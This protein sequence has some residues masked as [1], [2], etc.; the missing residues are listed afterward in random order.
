M[1]PPSSDDRT[2][3][4]SVVIAT[5]NTRAL[6]AAALTSLVRSAPGEILEI[7]VV[8]NGSIDGSAEMIREQF[9]DVHLIRLEKNTGYAPANNRGIRASHGTYVL[10]LG[11]DTAVKADTLP[12]MRRFLDDHP[13]VSAVACRLMNPDGTPQMSCRRFPRLRDAVATYLSLYSL[14]ARYVMKDFDFYRTQEV[15]QPAA[16]SLMV[17]REVLEQL[18]GFD[19]AYTI[20]Y[21]DVD[22]CRRMQSNGGRIFYLAETEVMHHGS[23]TTRN[24]PPEIRLEM[25][26]NILLYFTRHHG[27]VARWV[28]TPILAVRLCAVTRSLQGFRLLHPALEG[29]GA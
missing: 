20:L 23:S 2:P 13:D 27:V 14:T 9:P 19:E 8:D 15:E 24:A 21:N 25:Y 26:R 22:L 29:R 6:V 18:G 5:W 28:L 4:C 1:T 16:T 11:S 3:Q 12:V 17:R 7:I 10:L